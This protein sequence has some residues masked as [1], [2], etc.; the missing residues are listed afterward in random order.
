[1]EVEEAPPVV[2][3]P[4]ARSYVEPWVVVASS[5]SAVSARLFTHPLDTI[6]IRIQTAGHPVPPI[7]ELVPTPR[8]AS[9]Y[10]G[11]PVAI[12][13]SVPAL[14]VY[15]ATYEASKRYF[16]EHFLP[17]DREVGILQQLPV[18]VAAGTAAELASGAIW[19]PL[20]VL[21][22]RLQT[23]REGT[24]AIALTKKIVREEGWMGL[25]RGYWVGTAIFIPNISVYW[26]VYESLKSRYIPG[27]SATSSSS[28]R[29]STP[30]PEPT[31]PPGTIPLTLRYT[32]CS[33]TAC[34]IAATTT[35]P[36][37]IVQARWQTSGGKIEGGLTEIV[38][39]MWRT[40]GPMAFTRGLGIRIA[41]A[42]PANG[43]SMTMYESVKRWKGIS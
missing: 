6:R 16:S 27:Y 12:G 24:S 25:M 21:K 19:T 40:G 10:A 8:L 33:V 31:T 14:S 3:D 32:L 4:P 15:L 9:L 5:A 28:S 23:G 13:F 29:P 22:S 1:M 37:E 20:D 35:T 43:I 42:I 38:K 34:V 2:A 18:F 30:A 39:T 11:L 17:R 41:Y 7:R 36:I 26:S